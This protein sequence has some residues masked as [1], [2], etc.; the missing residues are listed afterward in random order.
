MEN[1]QK[2]LK[3]LRNPN[4]SKG[5]A[6]IIKRAKRLKNLSDAEKLISRITSEYIKGTIT[7]EESRN[8]NQLIQGFIAAHR[9][10][11]EEKEL[12]DYINLRF[13][14]FLWDALR[15]ID[16]LTS[17]FIREFKLDPAEIKKIAK[18]YTES[19]KIEQKKR[20]EKAKEILQQINNETSY[21]VKLTKENKP[22]EVKKLIQLA[23]RK[24]NEADRYQLL[25]EIKENFFNGE[26]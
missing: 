26:E 11:M 15:S 7:A 6:P 2:S 5:S 8:L 24:L 3:I 9:E 10:A 16:S 23:I 22:E 4:I 14:L 12:F 19:F 1:S 25:D 17:A 20:E 21:K 13:E 18:S